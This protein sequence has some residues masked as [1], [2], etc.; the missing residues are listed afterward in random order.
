M[1]ILLMAIICYFINGC[2]WLLHYK[3][4][5]VILCYITTIGEYSILNYFKLLY[6]K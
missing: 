2:W 5:L 3:L 6:L 1:A 4:L